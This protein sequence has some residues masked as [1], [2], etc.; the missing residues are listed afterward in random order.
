MRIQIIFWKETGFQNNLNRNGTEN[1]YGYL[2]YTA[3]KKVSEIV[4]KLYLFFS[5]IEH[6]GSK[7]FAWDNSCR[8]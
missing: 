1:P 3:A 5:N 6:I 4:E 7:Y 2:T 8:V